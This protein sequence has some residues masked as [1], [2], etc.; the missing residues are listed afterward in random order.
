MTETKTR[1][2][3]VLNW[4][5]EGV[6]DSADGLRQAASLARN[7]TFQAAFTER[8]AER[9]ALIG[10]LEAE[11]RSFGGEPVAEGSMIGDVHHAFTKLRDLVA[12]GSDKAVVEEASRGEGLIQQRFEAVVQDQQAP[13]EA[14]ALARRFGERL[15][16]DRQ[17]I[18]ELSQQFR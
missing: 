9:D 2:A 13:P 10:E 11:V 14:R 6:H 3:E 4:L 15:K 8:A 16:A 12:H 18:D 7:P 17:P 1:T 5:L